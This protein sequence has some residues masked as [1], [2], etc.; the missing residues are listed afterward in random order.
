MSVDNM[1]TSLTLRARWR[2]LLNEGSTAENS[3]E[4]IRIRE[5]DGLG[6]S[7]SDCPSSLSLQGEA[8]SLVHRDGGVAGEELTKIVGMSVCL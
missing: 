8:M 7:S 2:L 1:L 4:E 3:G 6:E 5:W